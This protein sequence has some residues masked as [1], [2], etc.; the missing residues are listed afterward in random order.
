MINNFNDQCLKFPKFK[1]SENT[2]SLIIF[3]LLLL[4]ANNN[5]AKWLLCNDK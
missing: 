3:K 5:F 4:I 2:G 1:D